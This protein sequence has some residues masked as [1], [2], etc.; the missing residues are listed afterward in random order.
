M[1]SI[2]S[3]VL[4]LAVGIVAAPKPA[5]A[6]TI[7]LGLGAD[8]WFE[9]SGVFDF[10]LAVTERL[11]RHVS[12]GGRFGMALVTSPSTAA[13]P[14]DL[15]LRGNVQHFYI[16]GLA[17]PWILFDRGDALHGHF[18]MGFGVQRGAISAGVE[19][20]YLDPNAIIGFRLAFAL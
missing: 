17:G 10:T 13:I 1:R 8:Y 20:G 16:E 14:L 2:R 9:Q 7:R 3:V 15:V 4:A 19:V 12:I 5:E 18:A 6:A 11:G